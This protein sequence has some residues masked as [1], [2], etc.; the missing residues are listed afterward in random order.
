[1]KPR[2]N[3]S[4]GGQS[5]PQWKARTLKKLKK[6]IEGRRPPMLWVSGANIMKMALLPK[7]TELQCNRL[8]TPSLS[9]A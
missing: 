7:V 4:Q 8:W 2:N 3:T 6:T 5:P 1:M 9:P